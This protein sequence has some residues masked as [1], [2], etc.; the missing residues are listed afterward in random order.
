M[1]VLFYNWVDY[2]DD[3]K[4]G[5]GVTVYQRNVIRALDAVEDVETV[6]LSS[7]ISYDLLSGR[8]RWEKVRHGPVENRANR[9]E[10]INSGVLS[11]SHHSFG[12]RAQVSQPE[13]AE[14]FFD[15]MRRKG[16]FDV[17]HFNNLEG[18][19]AEV[20]NLKA[21]FPDTRVVLSLHN[22]YPFCPQVNLWFQ[23]RE[24][25]VDFEMGRKCEH[26][27]PHRHDERIV[28]LANAVAFNMKKWGIRPGSRMFDRAFLPSMRMAR[29]MVGA[30]A[31][32]SR[33]GRKAMSL[34]VAPPREAGNLAQG[35]LTPL[36]LRH[37][38][39]D[40]RRLDIVTLINRHCDMVLGVSNRVCDVAAH[41]GVRPSL[42]RTSYIGTNQAEK[43]DLTFAKPSILRPDGTL[44]L[45]YLGYMRQDK[46]FFFLLHALE[47]LPAEVAARLRLVVCAARGDDHTMHRLAALSDRFAGL[48][49]ANGYS[50]DHLDDLLD[51]VDVG[52]VPVLWE[53]N[54]PQVAIE[55][56]ARHI[57]LLTSDLG[58]A[59]E[60]SNCAEMVFAA[61]SISSFAERIDAILAG[62]IT[63]QAYWKD[64]QHPVSMQGHLAELRSIWQGDIA[65]LPAPRAI[66]PLLRPVDV[67]A[68]QEVTAAAK[69][70]RRRRGAAKAEPTE[71]TA[72]KS[73][74]KSADTPTAAA[75]L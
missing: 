42:L 6:F 69:P 73:A 2:L 45:A 12:N 11:P 39:F 68:V 36:T 75:A 57:P 7:G 16:P 48:Y 31:R 67:V 24:N 4:R 47:S 8:P 28:R 65:S 37:R 29:R 5:G 22:Y 66:E 71:L 56:H 60:L 10:L 63:P 13:T 64:A 38:D 72:D 59:K 25:C 55:M 30:Y 14:A 58:G 40:T 50:H 15:F 33:K 41:F 23:E 21:H 1:R 74:D 18:V 53:D 17:V 9:Y 34:P 26:C 35:L 20:L 19:P 61:G 32:L 46:G 70:A 52:L 43:F 44:T 3:E 49:Y 27:L 54:L 62:K 51:D